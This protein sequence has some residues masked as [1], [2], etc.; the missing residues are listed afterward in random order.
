MWKYYTILAYGKLMVKRESVSRHDNLLITFLVWYTIYITI[1]SDKLAGRWPVA[2]FWHCSGTHLW[3]LIGLRVPQH[4]AGWFWEM[5]RSFKR[6]FPFADSSMAWYFVLPENGFVLSSAHWKIISPV[7]YPTSFPPPLFF[8]SIA[9]IFY[10]VKPIN[11][12]PVVCYELKVKLIHE[13]NYLFLS[14]ACIILKSFGLIE[15]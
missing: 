13:G 7:L 8:L 11:G 10:P 14:R 12:W 9:W 4:T 1:H 15:I 6:G 5:V 2:K 3:I